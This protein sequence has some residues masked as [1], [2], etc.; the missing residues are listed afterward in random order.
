MPIQVD[1]VP[2]RFERAVPVEAERSQDLRRFAGWGLGARISDQGGLVVADKRSLFREERAIARPFL[3]RGE[4]L[5]AVGQEDN[6]LAGTERPYV[7]V[8][9]VLFRY[10]VQVVVLVPLG[11]QV[12]LHLSTAERAQV[13]LN[14]G[15]AD[16]GSR[17]QE[18]DHEGCV[19]H[20]AESVRLSDVQRNA[21]RSGGRNLSRQ[22]RAQALVWGT[23][24]AQV[25]LVGPE[26][27]LQRLHRREVAA[28]VV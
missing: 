25:Y 15:L 10:C 5:L 20:C 24:K 19:D 7:N 28:R 18:S 9:P 3:S 26:H 1:V 8:L 6:A 11:T 13:L 14:V 21:P 16:V 12:D 27:V 17:D 4:R 23:L 2:Q 22:Q